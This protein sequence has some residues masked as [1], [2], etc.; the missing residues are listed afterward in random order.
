MSN[1]SQLPLAKEVPTRLTYRVYDTQ[2]RTIIA[3][4]N[5]TD[6]AV[7]PVV[8]WMKGLYFIEIVTRKGKAVHKVIVE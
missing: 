8:H 1:P 3:N 5:A 6:R 2:G 4:T 7:I